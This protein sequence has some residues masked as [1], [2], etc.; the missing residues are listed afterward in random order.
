MGV[1]K[2]SKS[3]DKEAPILKKMLGKDLFDFVNGSAQSILEYADWFEATYGIIPELRE[4]KNISCV[5]L[6]ADKFGQT[7]Y[8]GFLTKYFESGEEVKYSETD[9]GR[10]PEYLRLLAKTFGTKTGASEEE[11][12]KYILASLFIYFLGNRR[13]KWGKDALR[14]LY[15]NTLCTD[16]KSGIEE[17]NGIDLPYWV[18]DNLL[19]GQFKPVCDF[20]KTV[21]YIKSNLEH[22]IDIENVFNAEFKFIF[23]SGDREV[24]CHNGTFELGLQDVLTMDIK[25]TE[26]KSIDWIGTEEGLEYFNESEKEDRTSDL[27]ISQDTENNQKQKT[28][29]IDKFRDKF[30]E[31]GFDKREGEKVY[32]KKNKHTFFYTGPIGKKYD[33]E[34]EKEGIF[35]VLPVFDKI[36]NKFSLSDKFISTDEEIILL[37]NNLTIRKYEVGKIR[38][39]LRKKINDNALDRLSNFLNASVNPSDGQ[40][41]DRVRTVINQVNNEYGFTL[42]TG[43]FVL[44]DKGFSKGRYS[45]AF[46]KRKEDVEKESSLIA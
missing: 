11:A 2:S 35:P 16:A 25:D 32:D 5:S 18:E 41:A 28:Y 10:T 21:K 27:E 45:V 20:E 12:F 15:G 29:A 38:R 33:V 9:S 3:A 7:Q 36:S 44:S 6:N 31:V 40:N 13:E 42:D 1:F 4:I 24:L 14:A 43:M 26:L 34:L 22:L 23:V 17:E 46:A 19:L 30:E 39:S 37:D 8:T